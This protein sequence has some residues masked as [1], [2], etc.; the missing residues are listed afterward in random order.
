MRNDRVLWA[1]ALLAL[2]TPAAA[3]KRYGLGV[4]DSEIKIGRSMAFS[5]PASAYRFREVIRSE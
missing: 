2:A 4:S 1:P 3:Q 5:G